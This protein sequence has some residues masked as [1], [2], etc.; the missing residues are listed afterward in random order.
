[1]IVSLWLREGAFYVGF[2]GN[3]IKKIDDISAQ[4]ASV[5]TNMNLFQSQ[6]K[7]IQDQLA[8]LNKSTQIRSDLETKFNCLDWVVKSWDRKIQYIRRDV[9]KYDA[10][11]RY[12]EN[13]ISGGNSRAE[14]KYEEY[15]GRGNTVMQMVQQVQA[16]QF[17]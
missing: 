8:I 4:V 15:L 14:G 13:I 7:E 3:Y 5:K 6:L 17:F 2:S 12:H 9:D 16:L 11:I 10:L 1:M